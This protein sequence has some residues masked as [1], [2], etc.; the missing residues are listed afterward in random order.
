[1]TSKWTP[2]LA[3]VPSS[4]AS[5]A[6]S[7]ASS[8]GNIKTGHV[9]VALPST[10]LDQAKLKGEN[11][12]ITARARRRRE[13]AVR[14]LVAD[15]HRRPDGTIGGGAAT[16]MPTSSL[17]QQEHDWLVASTV[18]TA[19]ERGLDRDLHAELVQECKDN[20]SRIGQVCHADG[21]GFLQSVGSVVTLISSSVNSL[22]RDIHQASEEL[23][24]NETAG[25]MLEAA[26]WWHHCKTSAER[27]QAT[28]HLVQ[29]CLDVAVL[30]QRARKQASLGRPRAAL[31]AVDE[32]RQLLTAPAVRGTSGQ[33]LLLQSG[34]TAASGGASDNAAALDASAVVDGTTA[35]AGATSTSSTTAKP[36]TV[37]LRL[38][39]TPFGARA[40]EM[41]PK[42]ENE[43]LMGA[44]RGLNRWFLALRS[45]GDGA[46]AGR[47][48]LRKCAH[49]M[50][51]GGPG[52]L[53]LGGHVPPSYMWRAKTADNFCSRLDQ[54]GRVA[55]AVRLGYWFERDATKES[56][57]LERVAL[58][59]MERRAEAFAAA[60]GWYRCWDDNEALMV[61][62]AEM[63]LPDTHSSVH[64]AASSG[65]SGSRHGLGGS[66]HGSR[67]GRRTLGFRAS[68]QS[69]TASSKIE[70][71]TSTTTSKS[72]KDKK[73]SP[74]AEL[75]TPPIIFEDAPTR[76][77]K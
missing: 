64:G 14:R 50:A 24:S 69:K 58:P 46:K 42:I 72:G 26:E 3:S 13:E 33:R 68:T 47:A 19:L 17:S 57:R 12:T 74:W 56:E 52:Q 31:D 34:A 7:T 65:L 2:N 30:L 25:R 62:I 8:T 38:Q 10:S 73:R 76:W 63:N 29:S 6:T 39:E 9:A 71:R 35:A 66:R 27:A 70:L 59:G 28:R 77:V 60:F 11:S 41:L 44:R 55:R 5:V 43:V 48:V 40:M 20:S 23:T 4:Q 67:H 49:S 32:A 16:M 37:V 1:M 18:A 61:D 15:V 22:Q 53:G 54:N 36:S 51:V 45:G 21:D 75:L